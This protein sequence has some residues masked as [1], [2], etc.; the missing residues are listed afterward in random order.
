MP[1]NAVTFIYGAILARVVL[2]VCI[3]QISCH[4]IS[5]SLQFI[6]ILLY[7]DSEDIYLLV[8]AKITKI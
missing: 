6:N 2:I 4:G 1:K 7:F 5:A 3:T 8:Y